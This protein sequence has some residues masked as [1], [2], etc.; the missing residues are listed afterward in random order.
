MEATASHDNISKN[1][2]DSTIFVIHSQTSWKI[3][4][5]LIIPNGDYIAF[6]L[7]KYFA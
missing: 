3:K 6:H 2:D 4:L 7:P 5:G 1:Q